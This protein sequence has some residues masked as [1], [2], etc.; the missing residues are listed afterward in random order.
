MKEMEFLSQ[1]HHPNVVGYMGIEHEG[2]CT[3]VFLEYVPGGSIYSLL[4]K[5]GS[6]DEVGL[7]PSFSPCFFLYFIL[8]YFILVI[9]IIWLIVNSP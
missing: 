2:N 5:F 9:I 7:P 4:G 8:F 3:N 1:L 6:F